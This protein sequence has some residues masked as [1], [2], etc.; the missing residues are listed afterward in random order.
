MLGATPR[1]SS[2]LHAAFVQFSKTLTNL[3]A[4][5]DKAAAH[6]AARKFDPE[7]LLL[8]RLAPDQFALIRQIQTA[9]DTAKLGASRL[10]GKPAPVHADTEKTIAEVRGRIAE[11][12]AYLRDFTEADFEG[13]EARVITTPR[14]EGKTLTGEQY[15]HQHA[16]PNFYFHVGMAYAILRHNGVDIGKRD[17]LGPMPYTLPNAS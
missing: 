7:T 11:T 10:T 1:A 4:W 9:C 17:Y 6:A 5:F 14:W 16:I 3:D 2:V 12:V 15:A 13:A 8:A